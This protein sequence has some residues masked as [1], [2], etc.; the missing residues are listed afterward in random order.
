MEN[1]REA[2][3]RVLSKLNEIQPALNGAGLD[4]ESDLVREMKSDMTVLIWNGKPDPVVVSQVLDSQ[5]SDVMSS[6][7][8]FLATLEKLGTLNR[9]TLQNS[10]T[11]ADLMQQAM[12]S[13]ENFAARTG[14]FLN[15]KQL[16]QHLG[17]DNGA[18]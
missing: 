10:D 15:S 1:I 4:Y 8:C 14:D 11:F 12:Y 2:A 3:K 9:R 7:D 16:F 17:D 13:A 5:F 18:N 6:M